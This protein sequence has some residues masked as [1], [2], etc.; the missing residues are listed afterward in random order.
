MFMHLWT[1]YLVLSIEVFYSYAE[2][3]FNFGFGQ[4]YIPLIGHYFLI[5]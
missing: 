3:H 2:L 1:L 4:Y 5:Q